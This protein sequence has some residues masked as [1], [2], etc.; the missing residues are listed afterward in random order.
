MY[1]WIVSFDTKAALD[2][3]KQISTIEFETGFT[4]LNFVIIQSDLDK[5][6]ILKIEGVTECIESRTGSLIGIS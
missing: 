3:L 6:S 1:Q 5:E 2:K 4:E